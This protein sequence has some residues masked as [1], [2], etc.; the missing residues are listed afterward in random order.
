MNDD[1]ERKQRLRHLASGLLFDVQEKDGGFTLTRTA[2]VTTP[3][4][5]EDLSFAQAEELL[6]IWKLRGPHGG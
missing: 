2:D 3:V 1:A 5:E 4:H 6:N